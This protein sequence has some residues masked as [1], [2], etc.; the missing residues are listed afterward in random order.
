MSMKN[1]YTSIEQSQKLVELGLSP[2]LAEMEYTEDGTLSPV[3]FGTHYKHEG[4]LPSWSVMSLIKIM[5]IRMRGKYS[6]IYGGYWYDSDLKLRM[7]NEFQFGY[8]CDNIYKTP[9]VHETKIYQNIIDAAF[10]MVV[11]LLANDYIKPN[12]SN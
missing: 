11:W 4:L 7:K 1:V 6:R 9:I 5:P 12:N 3:Y 8:Y 10:E 2:E